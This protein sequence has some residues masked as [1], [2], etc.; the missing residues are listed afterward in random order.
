MINPQYF[1]LVAFLVFML[2]R[3]KDFTYEKKTIELICVFRFNSK[4]V[5]VGSE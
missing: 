1:E 5:N 4:S 2:F 3:P